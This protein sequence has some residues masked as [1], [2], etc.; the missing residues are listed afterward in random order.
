M[1]SAH[2]THFQKYFQPSVTGCTVSIVCHILNHFNN[3]CTFAW[4]A[5]KEKLQR[6]M[7]RQVVFENYHNYQNQLFQAG[8]ERSMYLFMCERGDTGVLCAVC[9]VH[10][11]ESLRKSQQWEFQTKPTQ[12]SPLS[13]IAVPACQ[14]IQDGHSASLCIRRLAGSSKTPAT[15][16]LEKKTTTT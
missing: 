5:A 4:V 8:R 6:P 11:I 14:A 12:L 15:A 16:P 9:T 3:F 10:T 7:R 2:L 13:G 1:R